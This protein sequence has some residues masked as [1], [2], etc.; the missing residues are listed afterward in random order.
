MHSYFMKSLV[1]HIPLQIIYESKQG[2]FSKRIIQVIKVG[3]KDIVAY[4]FSKKQYRTFTIERILAVFPY[5]NKG[6]SITA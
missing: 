1:H 3:E 2:L 6:N 5:K 4:C